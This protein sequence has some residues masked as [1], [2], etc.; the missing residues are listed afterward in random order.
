MLDASTQSARERILTTAHRL[1]YA[2]GVRATGI[3]RIIAEADVAKMSFYRHFPSKSDLVCAFLEERHTN[4]MAWF[5]GRILMLSRP[6][7][8][9]LTAAASALGEW[10]AEP[11]FRGCAFIN[12]VAECGDG[13]ARAIAARHKDELATA[14]T[15]IAR[16]QGL[17]DP[18]AA[19]R[20]ALIIV[21]GAIVRA[22]TTGRGDEA[23]N[24]AYR[25]LS[26]LI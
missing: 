19:G 23:A 5:T 10:F 1:F 2:H 21:D 22:Q 15:N 13:A 7:T 24:D 4:W 6:G 18:Q 11:E 12:I 17:A 25:L 3:D 9:Q 8:A 14:L 16:A 20:L 26:G